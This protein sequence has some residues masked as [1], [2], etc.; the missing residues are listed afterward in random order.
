MVARRIVR[1][2]KSVVPVKIEQAL[3]HVHAGSR[4]RRAM[5]LGMKEA[6]TPC[7]MAISFTTSL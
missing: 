5:G 7:F 6:Y 4:A 2:E 1:V 3:V